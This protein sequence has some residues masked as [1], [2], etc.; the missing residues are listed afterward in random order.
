[1]SDLA[2]I[3]AAIV[4]VPAGFGLLDW[5]RPRRSQRRALPNQES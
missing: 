5:I 4:L 2:I 1:M 3:L